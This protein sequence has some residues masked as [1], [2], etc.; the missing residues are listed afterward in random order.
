MSLLASLFRRKSIVELAVEAGDPNIDHGHGG[1]L[2]RQ[3]GALDLTMLGVGGIIGAGIFTITGG[4]AAKFAGP[5]V[6]FITGEEGIGKTRLID[7]FAQRAALEGAVV[8]RSSACDGDTVGIGTVRQAWRDGRLINLS[9]GR[10][11]HAGD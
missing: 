4:A 6:V 11:E 10:G 1:G 2:K 5:G 3:L 8:H 7:E 9:L